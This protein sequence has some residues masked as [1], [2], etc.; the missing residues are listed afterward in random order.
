MKE[1][2]PQGGECRPLPMFISGEAKI[3]KFKNGYGASIVC[4]QHSYGGNEG[5]LELA[6]LKGD[7][8]CYDTPVTDDVVGYL[9]TEKATAI[10]EEI[11]A[12][13]IVQS[14]PVPPQP[15]A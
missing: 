15:V 3:Y 7:S 8:I 1:Q 2:F 13:P 10:L 5:L 6:V 11:K 12:L 4:H 9:T 14:W